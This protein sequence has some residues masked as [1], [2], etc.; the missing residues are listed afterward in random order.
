MLQMHLLASTV[1][2][3]FVCVPIAVFTMR[4]TVDGW[5]SQSPSFGFVKRSLPLNVLYHT[6]I[7]GYPILFLSLIGLIAFFYRGLRGDPLDSL[8][9][10]NLVVLVSVLAF[11]S[12]VP[13][14]LEPRKLFMSIPSLLF[15]AAFGL[16]AVIN[17]LSL[18]APT[19]RAPAFG[20][21]AIGGLLV[22]WYGTQP[23]AR[24]HTNMG[25]VAEGVLE[26]PKM[27]RSVILVASTASD[28]REEL[29]FV[30]EVAEREN[31]NF[32][33][34]IVRAGKFMADSS[35]MGSDYRPR[36]ATKAEASAAIR[37]VPISQIVLYKGNDVARSTVHAQLLDQM[38]SNERAVWSCFRSELTARG[39]IEVLTAKWH[40]S[41]Q[42][43][44]PSIDMNRKLR[45]SIIAEF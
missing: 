20:V 34:A 32:D 19:T 26:N 14:S 27:R 1:G 30:A 13:T 42:I 8:S 21:L 36:Y 4:M 24:T 29:S 6:K 18:G 15:F 28:E 45:R 38:I 39:R 9:L 17:C 5:D 25:P 11:H 2:V 41:D 16:R 33:H 3:L 22:Y 7:V 10:C 44:L 31:A 23:I 43:R 35:W 40:P 37:S 12:I